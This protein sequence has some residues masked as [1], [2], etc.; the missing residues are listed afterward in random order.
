MDTKTEGEARGAAVRKLKAALQDEGGRLL[1]YMRVVNSRV[2]YSMPNRPDPTLSGIQ[3]AMLMTAIIEAGSKYAVH[4]RKKLDADERVKATR[5]RDEISYKDLIEIDFES[6]M[7]SS[8]RP[9]KLTLQV[10]AIVVQ[11]LAESAAKQAAGSH[12]RIENAL[13][14]LDGRPQDLN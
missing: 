7:I 9:K 14:Q 2:D 11:H 4:K 6:G 12:E 8:T 10:L 13:Q 5:G 3:D 1:V